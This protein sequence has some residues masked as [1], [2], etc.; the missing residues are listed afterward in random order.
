MAGSFLTRYGSFWGFVP[1]TSGRVFW[2]APAATYTVEG[3]SC[4]AANE[5]RMGLS[6]DKAFLTLTYAFTQCTANVGD[7]IMLLPGAHS[8]AATAACNVAGVSVFGIRRGMPLERSRMP[9]GGA[10]NYTS[11]TVSTAALNVLTVTAADI[12]IAY[13]HIIPLA[14]T[15]GIKPSAAASRLYV[16][17]CTFNM[18]TAADTATTGMD[19]TWIGTST[20]LDD[21]IVRNCYFYVSDNQGP[22]IRMQGTTLDLTIESCT[23]KLVGDTAWDDAVELVSTSLGTTIRDCDFLQRSSGTVMTDAI[24]LTGATI[25]GSTTI[26]RCMFAVGSDPTEIANVADNQVAE[27]YLMQAAA[28]VGGTLMIPS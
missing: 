4:S 13:L 9:A 5:P 27:N 20:T 23:F 21:V 14:A 24:D 10:R 2:V 25:D 16:H 26:L 18:S 28:S 19:G 22:A 1:Q 11:V 6:P 12:E 17:D 3:V 7:I 15:A 8:W